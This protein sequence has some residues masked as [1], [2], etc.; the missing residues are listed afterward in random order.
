[1]KRN[2][3]STQ[4]QVVVRMKRKVKK[5]AIDMFYPCKKLSDNKYTQR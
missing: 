1:M 3:N 4:K 5:A 2:Q